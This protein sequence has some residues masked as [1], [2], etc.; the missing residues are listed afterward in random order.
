LIHN[1]QNAERLEIVDPK[2]NRGWWPPIGV[3]VRVSD[4]TGAMV[5]HSTDD[6]EGWWTRLSLSSDWRNAVAS[7]GFSMPPVERPAMLTLDSGDAIDVELDPKQ[8]V[9]GMRPEQ[10]PDTD[11]C[12]VQVRVAIYGSRLQEA[13]SRTTDWQEMPC[14]EVFGADWIEYF[15]ERPSDEEELQRLLEIEQQPNQQ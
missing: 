10:V 4:Q 5:R 6:D 7:V 12:R 2:F 3:Y 15:R 9:E 14:V 8:L 11:L 13:V 1:P